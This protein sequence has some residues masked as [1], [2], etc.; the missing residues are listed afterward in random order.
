MI[1]EIYERDIE[2]E[3]SCLSVCVSFCVYGWRWRRKADEVMGSG[4]EEGGEGSDG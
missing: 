4:R 2:K 3:T 1:T